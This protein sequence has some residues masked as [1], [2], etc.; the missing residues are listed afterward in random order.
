[1]TEPFI[2][3]SLETDR[4]L[5]RPFMPKDLDPFAEMVASAEV[6]QYAT[7]NGD[8]MARAQAWNWLCLMLGH[9]HMRGYGLWAIEEKNTGNLLGRVG[10]QFL[11]W[12]DDVELVWML[13]QS[14]WGKGFATEGARATI[15]FGMDAIKLPRVT[16]V[17]RRENEPS[18][19]L[20]KRLG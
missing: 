13:K 3:P 9:W 20:A 1:M 8:P 18:I 14:A 15:N 7:Y 11:D 6:M 10:L 2:I 19:R 4:L 12:F 17:I 16:S 5:L